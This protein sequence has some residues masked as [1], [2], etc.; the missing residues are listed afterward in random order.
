[1]SIR[2]LVAI[3]ICIA[4][5]TAAILTSSNRTPLA[6]SP[7]EGTAKKSVPP[8]RSPIAVA[9]HSNGRICVT[10]NHTA[11]S[12]SFV[13]LKTRKVL[14]EHRCGNGPADV[15]WIDDTTLLVS[16][17]HDDAVALVRYEEKS[18][19][20]KTIARIPVGDEPHGIA[21]LKHSSFRTNG[22]L[23]FIAIT[24]LNQVAVVNLSTK[25]VIHRI[26]VGGLPR[27]VSV[28][29]NGKW[30]V[31]CCNVPGMIYV[32]KT[33]TFKQN[34]RRPVFDDGFNLG[35]PFIPPDSSVIVIPHQ[36]N[37]TFP[38]HADNVEKGWVIDNRLTRMPLPD[39]KYW[40]QKQ[41]G[42]DVRGK[43]AGD[44]NALTQSPDGRWFAVSCG[45]S[46]ELLIID[47]RQ[48]QWPAADPGDFIPTEL[49]ERKGALRR[50]KLGGRPVAVRMLDGARV[51]AN[52]LS[53][54][55]QIVDLA[56]GKLEATIPLGGP[57]TTSLV[58][59]GETIFYDA[60]R[61]LDSWFSCHTCHTDG[62]TSGQTFDTVSDGNYDTYKLVPSL[63][64]VTR[65]GPWTWHGWQK[66]LRAGLHKSLTDT[67][68][69]PKPSDD[70][71]TA[72]LAYLEALR[73][74]P[75]PR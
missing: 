17:Q 23:A 66:D 26:S 40:E 19:T 38:V 27:S 71:V 35:T 47:R 50:V 52:S 18:A 49:R 16:L 12:I 57:E 2:L 67:M 69:G 56:A 41:V 28:S 5:F 74:P 21:L 15:A 13:D 65:T 11:G 29:P 58:R 37:R 34:S 60:D 62:H 9:V 72:L 8:H 30:L 63:R 6:A 61:S 10:A 20:A 70:D 42:L 44:V 7:N 64:G 45:G 24:G 33:R 54:S 31:T 53:N 73:P 36:I 22:H 48:F 39:G 55:L 1:M 4:G 14:F 75:A 32:H 25:K 59:R 43:A 46:H 3:S 51:V 68:Q